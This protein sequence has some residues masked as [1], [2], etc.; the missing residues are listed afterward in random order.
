MQVIITGGTGLIGQKLTKLLQSEGHEVAWLSRSSKSSSSVKIFQWDIDAEKIDAEAFKWADACIHLAGAGVAEKRWT[1]ERKKVILE[2]RVKST[3]LLYKHLKENN[4]QLKSFIGASATGY[5][6][7]I[8]SDS[9][10]TLMDE[11]GNDFLADVTVA[12]EEEVQKISSL[13]IP[14]TWIRTGIVLSKEGGALK[15]MAKPPVLAPLGTGN[16]WMPWIHIDDICRMYLDVLESNPGGPLN[17]VAPNPVTNEVFTKALAKT[18]GK[19]YV[20]VPAPKFVLKLALGEMSVVLTEGVRVEANK[21][22]NYKFPQLD[23]AL[24]DLY[25]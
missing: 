9:V 5:Y 4:I 23:Q 11:P 10:K 18:T 8:T 2:S 19:L 15:E 16:Q 13:N 25:Q 17:G 1:D 22:F 6:G 7:S 12:W 14:T 20:P 3:Q 21:N 24:A